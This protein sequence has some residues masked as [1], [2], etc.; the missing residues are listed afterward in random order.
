MATR[1]KEEAIA[2]AS[3]KHCV[4]VSEPG[5]KVGTVNVST[6]C[7]KNHSGPCPIVEFVYTDDSLKL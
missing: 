4:S 3:G 7:L 5:E 1:T 2:G 6:I